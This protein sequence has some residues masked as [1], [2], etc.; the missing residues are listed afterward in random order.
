MLSVNIQPRDVM[1]HSSPFVQI[2]QY[3]LKCWGQAA[4]GG[5]N[6]AGKDFANMVP[7][8]TP[9]AYKFGKLNLY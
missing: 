5:T 2:I 3:R 6:S 8:S 4:D 7:A 1:L 9:T